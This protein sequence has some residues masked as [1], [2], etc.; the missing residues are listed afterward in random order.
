MPVLHGVAEKIAEDILVDYMRGDN[1]E[2]APN[3]YN[4]LSQCV[5][6]MDNTAEMTCSR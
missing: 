6:G 3:W 5:V 1:W 4:G 2:D